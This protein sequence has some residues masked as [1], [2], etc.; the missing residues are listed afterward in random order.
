MHHS[1][2]NHSCAFWE[3][4]SARTQEL[5][6]RVITLSHKSEKSVFSAFIGFIGCPAGQKRRLSGD[7]GVF[8]V[9]FW[10]RPTAKN[11]WL[12]DVADAKSILE[13]KSR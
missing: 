7:V 2:G 5:F 12:A 11:H 13:R 3:D 4:K 1:S 6:T 10:S 9:V 8:E